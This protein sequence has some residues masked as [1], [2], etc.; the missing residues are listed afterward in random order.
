MHLQGFSYIC[1]H[2]KIG[3]LADEKEQEYINKI[4][5]LTHE[6]DS[7]KH[8]N[9][10]LQKALFGASNERFV[11]SV[12]PNQQLLF[13]ESELGAEPAVE[14]P[15]ETITIEEHTKK[16]PKRK[17]LD[18]TI[19]DHIERREEIIEPENKQDDF[20]RIGENVT[21][22]L[23]IEPATIWVRR[24]VRPKYATPEG[25]I[26]TA[27]MPEMVLPKSN[28]GASLLAWM[29]INKFVDHMP[30]HR[31][32]KTLRREGVKIAES[33]YNGWFV[34]VSNLLEPLYDNLVKSVL[35][36]DYLKGDESTIPVQS[37]DKKGATHTGYMWVFQNP[38][39]NLIIFNYNKGRSKKVPLEFLK[40][41]KNGALQTDGYAG[42][43]EVVSKNKLTHLACW[44]H[45][46]RKF[47]ESLDNDK[48]RAEHVLVLI[49]KLYE[50]ERK[51]REEKL[52]VEKTKALREK[53]SV[54]VLNE[55][56][57]Y[58]E[59][60]RNKVL[61]KS[62]IGKAIN[63]TLNLW[64]QLSAYTQNGKFD[65]DNNTIE[66]KIRPLALGRK[67]YLFAGSHDSAQRVAMMYSFLGSCAA[68]NINPSKWLNDVLCRIGLHHANKL[69]EL[70]P[71]VENFPE[72][73]M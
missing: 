26:V 41:F 55:I 29:I 50:I 13:D 38:Q 25:T 53:E 30:F 66:N 47:V 51:A 32:L 19:P 14:Q 65:I 35:D 69:H 46:R 3:K 6:V 67:N 36:T 56:K 58:L 17:P 43:F 52:S 31:Q 18:A 10:L 5:G 40:D 72:L 34:Q 33:T 9:A 61:P 39:S 42:Y 45:A 23:E 71:T 11:S 44:A 70:L 2:L 20:L 16:K 8:Q 63:Y 57:T 68:N 64:S 22:V 48:I 15:E 37:K 7:L 1:H 59:V 21:E 54:S 73:C 24:I 28:A 27:D 12:D 49:Q 4:E 62:A 60:E